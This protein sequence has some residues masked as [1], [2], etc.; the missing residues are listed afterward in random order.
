MERLLLTGAGGFLGRYLHAE[1]ARRRMEVIAL[2]R[3]PAQERG[4]RA[5]DLALPGA[6]ARLVEELRPEAVLHAGALARIH[7]CAR[8]PGL[9]RRVNG[10]ATAELAWAARAAGAQFLYVS[11]D[12]VFSGTR[13]P[14]GPGDPPEPVSVYGESKALGEEGAAAAGGRIVR[15]ALLYGKSADG[16]TGASDALLAALAR[17]ERPV[18]FSDEFRTPLAVDEAAGAL[19]DLLESAGGGTWHLGGP[20]R[21]DRSALGRLVC[22]AAGLDEGRLEAGLREQSPEHAGRP[23]D[24]SML[25][26]AAYARLAQKPS[27]PWDALRRIYGPGPG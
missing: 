8:E 18:L 6:A 26:A 2:S 20:E 25:S 21:L 23:P 7:Q 3:R 11:T 1:A 19:L 15:I 16:A 9:A 5:V 12:Q 4:W 22:R 14:Y 27:R 13:A 17:G 10:E 24:L